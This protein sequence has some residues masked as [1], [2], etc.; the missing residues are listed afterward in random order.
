MSRMRYISAHTARHIRIVGLSTALA[1]ARDLADWL[2]IEESGLFNFPPS[3]RPVPLTVHIAGFPGKYYCPRMSLMNKPTYAAIMTHSRQK[4]VLVFVSSRR[5]TRLTGLD[6]IA[7]S[8]ADGNPRKFLHMTDEELEG[9]M[10]LVRDPHLKHMLSFGIGMHHAGLVPADRVLVEHL[11][12]ELKIQVLVCTSTLAWG[13]N[14]PAHLVVIKG[15]EYYNALTKSYVDFP[16]TGRAADDGPSRQAA[17]RRRRP[18]RW[19]WW[20]RARRTSISTSSTRPSPSRARSPL[21]CTTTSTRR[22][23]GG[24]VRSRHDAVQYITWT[25]LYR[26]LLLNPSYYGVEGGHG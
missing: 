2:G 7:F 9:T 6:L 20:R 3:V 4:P 26:R 22:W 8:A 24:T 12:L 11:Y 23:W 10:A 13:V 14:F 19:C 15:T 16:I 25:F 5:Q 18:R 1:N 21:S 17:V